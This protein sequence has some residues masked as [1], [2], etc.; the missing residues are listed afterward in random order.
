[1]ETNVQSSQGDDAPV[2]R[3]FLENLFGAL[4]E[5]ITALKEDI[6][7]HVKHVQRDIGDLGQRLNYLEQT[8]TPERKSLDGH[9]WELLELRDTIMGLRYR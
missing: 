5:D 2:T 1:M 6:A 9:H 7:A 8:M 4:Q 3:A